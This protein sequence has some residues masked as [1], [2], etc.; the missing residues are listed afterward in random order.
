[1][2]LILTLYL[3]NPVKNIMAHT[4]FLHDTIFPDP[5]LLKGIPY[6]YSIPH[7]IHKSSVQTQ[8]TGEKSD[9]NLLHTHLQNK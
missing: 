8:H 7:H 3:E 2:L 4:K 9:S 5:K 6:P 1:M